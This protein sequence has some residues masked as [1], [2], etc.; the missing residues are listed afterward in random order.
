MEVTLADS[1]R[2]LEIA[3]LFDEYRNF[4]Q[5]ESNIEGALAFLKARFKNKDSVIFTA[6]DDSRMAGFA[7]LY[8]SFSSVSMKR[9]WILNDLFVREPY[10]RKNVAR[11]LMSAAKN[12]AT[13]TNAVRLVIAT[14]VSNFPAQRLYESLG[15]VKDE[16]FFNYALP[17]G[18]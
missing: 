15:Y 1:T 2:V 6:N 16:E 5:K 12:H 3:R 13:A 10:R 18:K 17:L 4:Y 7:Q 14:Q 8:P 11:Q 9:I